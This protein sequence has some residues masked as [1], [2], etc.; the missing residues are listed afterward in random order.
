MG[1]CFVMRAI[2]VKKLNDFWKKHADS[3]QALRAWFEEVK[4][5][6]W[7]NPNA[8][9]KNYKTAS[10]LPKNRVV[11][12]IKG[13]KYRLIVAIKYEFKIVYIR[14]IG[15]HKEYDR[16]NAKEILMNINPIRTKVDYENALE[17]IEKLWDTKKGSSLGDELEI[18]SIL[19]EKYEEEN[20]KI[21]P[22]DPIEAIKFR[23]EQ[24]NLK[25]SDLAPYLGGKNRVSEILHK[26]RNLTVKMIKSLYENLHIP[27][28]SLIG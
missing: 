7:N 6:V 10:F 24:L 20:Y 14:F 27:A 26:K 18:L 15:T 1:I 19:I 28:E 22:P 17:R 11:F 2:A 21:C 12:N 8:I 4:K 9:K 13:N 16:I 5:S 3:E 25:K 23:I